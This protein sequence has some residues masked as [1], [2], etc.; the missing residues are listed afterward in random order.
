MTMPNSEETSPEQAGEGLSRRSFL[1]VG[2]VG[3]AIAAVAGV[4]LALRGPAMRAVPG[5]LKVLSDKEYAIIA[6]L[7]DVICPARGPSLP[8]A[9]AIDV[10]KKADDLFATMPEAAQKD[11]KILLNVFDNALTGLLFEGR[12]TPFSKL[13]PEAQVRSFESWAGSGVAFRRTAYHALR[14]MIPA[15]YYSDERI[16]K[17]VGYGGPPDVA[18]IRE[19]RLAKLEQEQREAIENSRPEAIAARK[20]QASQELAEPQTEEPA[21]EVTP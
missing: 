4:G 10:A 21:G 2:L 9:S 1:K 12:I 20:A 18:D 8:G 6:A 11:F 14:A 7:G 19:Y 16:W 5:G 13:D 17:G 3:S 15:L